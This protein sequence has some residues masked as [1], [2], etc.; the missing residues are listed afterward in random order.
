MMGLSGRPRDTTA[1]PALWPKS[2]PYPAVFLPH[3]AA[4]PPLVHK[5]H[6]LGDDERARF[7]AHV[8]CSVYDSV[9]VLGWRTRLPSRYHNVQM[10]HPR[11]SPAPSKIEPNAALSQARSSDDH[12]I[13]QLLVSGKAHEVVR[14]IKSVKHRVDENT[15]VCLMHEGLGVLE[16]VRNMFLEGSNPRPN[17]MLGHMSHR[18]L[19]H[20]NS[21]SVKRVRNGDT[22]LTRGAS[23]ETDDELPMVKSLRRA[24]DLRVSLST[25]ESWLRF[26]LPS[27]IFDSVVEPVCV[28]LDT[29][30]KGLLQNRAAQRMMQSLL[31]EI[32]LVVQNMPEVEGSTVLGEFLR[33]RSI[34]R[35]IHNGIL[36][37]RSGPSQLV[38]RVDKG[39]PTDIDYLTGYFLRRGRQ[40]NLDMRANALV[41]DAVKARHSRA[42]ERL[43]SYVPVEEVSL[44]SHLE[45][46]YRTVPKRTA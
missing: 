44:P 26:K 40:L 2:R 39:L 25:Y 43:N 32:I 1:D 46:R 33:G 17:L 10:S 3:E 41:S 45:H 22:R 36:A 20:R 12:R 29:P 42:I 13:E 9:D 38:S 16:A 30:Y 24:R 7:M 4:K 14:S 11:Y 31:S 27:V 37:K 35:I 15:T 28:L 19:Y 18:L 23:P 8:L 21:D 34:E 5:I 6:I